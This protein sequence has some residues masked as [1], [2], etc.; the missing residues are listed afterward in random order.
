MHAIK[1]SE[2]PKIRCRYSFALHNQGSSCVSEAGQIRRPRCS[3]DDWGIAVFHVFSC[4]NSPI[5]G[6]VWEV[7]KQLQSVP[8]KY[9][10]TSGDQEPKF[11]L[12]LLI[13]ESLQY[14]IV[15]NI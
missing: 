6:V 5:L 7:W 15:R 12:R 4:F 14:K 2:L 8:A 10:M 13:A 1:D 11:V 3:G 9:S